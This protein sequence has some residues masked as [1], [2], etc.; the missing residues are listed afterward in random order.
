[1]SERVRERERER[2]TERETERERERVLNMVHLKA[3]AFYLCLEQLWGDG[4]LPGFAVH[5]MQTVCS[6]GCWLKVQG[7]QSSE[8]TVQAF[9]FF[10]AYYR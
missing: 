10:Q 3:E 8:C 9:R 7:R 4:D 5:S 1:M 6:Q 2:V